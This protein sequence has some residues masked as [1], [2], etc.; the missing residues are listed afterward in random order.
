MHPAMTIFN[1][2]LPD[3]LASKLRSRAAEAGKNSVDDYV[4]E[5]L[6]DHLDLLDLGPAPGV[7]DEDDPALEA[8][9][10][11]RMNDSRPGIEATPQFWEDLKRRARERREA[12]SP[13]GGGR[14]P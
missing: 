7:L 14:Q 4:R 6:R 12:R 9:L 3:D 1:L 13:S 8:E 11:R 5:L 2:N 10:L